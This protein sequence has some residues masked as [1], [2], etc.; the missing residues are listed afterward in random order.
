M[1]FRTIL[2]GIVLV[3][4][5]AIWVRQG[6]L[7]R[8]LDEIAFDY[9][10]LSQQV[11]T[12]CNDRQELKDACNKANSAYLRWSAEAKVMPLPPIPKGK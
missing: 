1:K 4:Q 9:K 12:V 2:V 11:E 3:F 10:C 7:E 8:R 6:Y 5:I